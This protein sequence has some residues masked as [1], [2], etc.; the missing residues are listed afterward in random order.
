MNAS[1]KRFGRA[2]GYTLGFAAFVT[3]KWTVC[4]VMGWERELYACEDAGARWTW[5]GRV[6]TFLG[7]L[8][9]FVAVWTLESDDR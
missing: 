2:L 9:V 5:F 1:I 4:R 7:I 8:I 6:A 3:A